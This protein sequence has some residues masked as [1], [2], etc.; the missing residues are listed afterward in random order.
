MTILPRSA[1]Q[2]IRTFVKVDHSGVGR[3]ERGVLVGG[4]LKKRVY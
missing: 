3:L 2:T 4:R 1:K